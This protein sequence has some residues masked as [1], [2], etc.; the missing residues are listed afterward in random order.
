[1]PEGDA[2]HRTARRLDRALSGHALE[3]CDFRV[4]ALATTDLT[5]CTVVSTRPLGKHILTRIAGEQE[6]TLHTH[7]GMDGSWRTLAPGARWSAPAHLVRVVLATAR[8]QALGV[9]LAKVELLPAIQEEAAFAHLGPDLMAPEPDLAEAVRRLAAD[10]DRTVHA[11][12]MDQRTMAGL[13]NMW[14]AELC[15]LRGVHPLTQVR[16][17]GDLDALVQL[18]RRLLLAN[19]DGRRSTS[20]G[21]SRAGRELWVYRRDRQ[22]C[23]RC[24]APVRVAMA[25]PGGRERA[26][27]WCDNCQPLRS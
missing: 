9:A 24:G 20:T 22:E 1:M 2:V 4:P 8:A 11:A 25:G 7:L 21:D 19:K 3:R 13:G 5:G 6:W 14:V 17:A 26:I 16:H 23:R 12:L 18:G 15:F 27:Y 10:P